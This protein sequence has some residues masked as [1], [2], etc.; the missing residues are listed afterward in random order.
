MYVF[1]YLFIYLLIY[2]FI[3]LLQGRQIQPLLHYITSLATPLLLHYI[4]TLLNL[5]TEL[6]LTLH[7]HH[8]LQKLLS[9]LTE[10]LPTHTATVL[11]KYSY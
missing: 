7:L 2:S 9:L 1:I 3:Y 10:L 5:L 11:T 6:V 8:K 4:V